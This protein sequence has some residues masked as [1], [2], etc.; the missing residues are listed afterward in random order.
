VDTTES[1]V[2]Y[3]LDRQAILDCVNLYSRGVDRH[4]EELIAAAYH[5]DAIDN[6]GRR[7]DDIPSFIQWVNNAHA[8]TF[9]A[10]THHITCHSCEITGDVAHAESYVFFVQRSKDGTQLMGGSG[11]Y[12]D[13][14]ERRDQVWKIALRRVVIDWR[15]KASDVVWDGPSAFPAGTWDRSDLSYM[16][17]LKVEA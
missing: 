17:P 12:I 15:F 3:L 11:R 5:A 16:R 13:R 9:M 10:H 1:K 8:S 7:V 6:H 2:Q 4:D 14:L